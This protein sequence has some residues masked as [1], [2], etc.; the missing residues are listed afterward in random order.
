MEIPGNKIKVDVCLP[1]YNEEKILEHNVLRIFEFCDKN[2]PH[3]DWKIV[4]LINGSTDNTLVIAKRLAQERE[5]ISFFNVAEA[6]R[7]GVLKKYFSASEADVVSYMDID[8]ASSL[9]YFL[10][11]INAT[12]RDGYDLSVGSR[13]LPDSKVERGFFRELISTVYN[14][15]S[16][17]ILNHRYSDMQ[18]GFKSVTTKAFKGIAGNITSN[19]WFFDTELIVWA[20][21]YGYKIKE[22][23]VNWI[24]DRYEKRKSKVKLVRD[25]FDFIKELIKLRIRL[26]RRFRG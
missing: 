17:F 8:L 24:E 19:K 22:V 23:P 18:C 9:E 10:A 5:H 15:L 3:L 2:F 13:F 11:L 4:I 25:I 7:G 21:K 16:R 14:F 1:V 12:T 20:A 6:G 26:N